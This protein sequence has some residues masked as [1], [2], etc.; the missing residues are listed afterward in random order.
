VYIKTGDA[1]VK[2]ERQKVFILRQNERAERVTTERP[3]ADSFASKPISWLTGI[4][5]LNLLPSGGWKPVSWVLMSSPLETWT[6]A[7]GYSFQ[8]IAR[9]G[10]RQFLKVRGF[11]AAV[12]RFE[13]GI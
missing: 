2:T 13:A 1:K 8:G 6:L 3:S 7:H 9:D 4:S 12:G 5:C 10:G 11:F